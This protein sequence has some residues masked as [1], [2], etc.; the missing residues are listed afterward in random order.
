M[1]LE[2]ILDHLLLLPREVITG[3]PLEI[4][5]QEPDLRPE[6]HEGS[7]LFAEALYQFL[8]EAWVI[9]SFTIATVSIAWGRG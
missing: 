4:A 6:R 5:A 7:S 3:G 2:K 9:H 1:P 8:D